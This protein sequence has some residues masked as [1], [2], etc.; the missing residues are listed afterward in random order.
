[1]TASRTLS[2]LKLAVY[3]S[4]ANIISSLLAFAITLLAVSLTIGYL[5]EERFGIWMTIASISSMLSFMDFGVGN[6]MVSQIARSN[7]AHDRR[8]LGLTA[9]RG[10]LTLATIGF[11]VGAALLLANMAFPLINILKIESAEARTDAQQLIL[12]FI[13]LFALNIPLGGLFKIMQGL[14][15]GW[16]VYTTRSCASALSL[17]LIYV[18]AQQEAPPV[19]LL[20]ATYGVTVLAP[21]A[22]LPLCMKLGLLTRHANR[23]WP[24]ARKEYRSL[25]N[26]GGL[27]LILQLGIM[28]GWGSDAFIISALTSVSAVAQFAIVQRLF[29]VVSI[30]MN[31]LN[32]PLWGAYADA[33]AHGDSAF[34]RKTL[35]IS[36]LGTLVLSSILSAGL[37]FTADWIMKY[38]L[39]G[40]IDV[41]SELILA[42]A[43]WKV[44]QSVGHSFSMALNGMHIVKVQVVSVLLLCA[45]AIPLKLVYT[46]EY[47]AI[48]VVWSTVAAYGVSTVLFYLVIFRRHIFNGWRSA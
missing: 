25:V 17:M 11:V 20:M 35:T 15:R 47:G 24:S 42:F 9:T 7:V 33:H 14:Q 19:Y 3:A 21:L 18:L 34:I 48:G 32:T 30:P 45:L 29:Q 40:H 13:V 10:L 31:I 37:Y 5:G 44:F 8:A 38:W 1:M 27:F 4:S 12:L 43:V 22:L 46:P 6:G 39:D 41:S 28:V 16:I 36:L 26:F 23:D 2:R